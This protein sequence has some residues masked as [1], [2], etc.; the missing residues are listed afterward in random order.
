MCERWCEIEEDST[1]KF[2]DERER[3]RKCVSVVGKRKRER[4]TRFTLRL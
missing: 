2:F 3:E 4:I 1:G